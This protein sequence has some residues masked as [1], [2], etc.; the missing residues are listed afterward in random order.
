MPIGKVFHYTP[1][2]DDLP[3]AEVLFNSLFAP[4]CF[5]RGY[6]AFWNR[7]AAIYAISEFIIEPMQPHPP[8]PPAPASSWY[9]FMERFGPRVLNIG[10]YATDLPL[11]AEAFARQG[12]RTTDAGNDQTL[13]TH[14]K[15]F[16]GMLEFFNPGTGGLPDPRRGPGWSSEYWRSLHPL[17]LD[18][19]SHITVVVRDLSRAVALYRDALGSIELPEQPSRTSG[20]RSAFV[21]VGPEVVIEL[22]EPVDVDCPLAADLERVGESICGCTF[23][24]RDLTRALTHLNNNNAPVAACDDGTVRL[25]RAKTFGSDYAFTDRPLI[26]DPR[27]WQ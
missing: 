12:V 14:P 23:A 13:F 21:T 27:T 9:R 5:Y 25:E 19:P 3:S 16:P 18:H 8:E 15:D 22:A 2:V 20:A 1:L 26:G 4:H 17:G 24:V 10:F 6:S 7:S 11:L